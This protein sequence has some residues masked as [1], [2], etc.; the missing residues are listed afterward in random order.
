MLPGAAAEASWPVP[1]SPSLPALGRAAF[2]ASESPQ[3]GWGVLGTLPWA[4]DQYLTAPHTMLHGE[5][6]LWD[7]SGQGLS[8]RIFGWVVQ[9]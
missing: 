4:F 1:P 9:V 8:A 7:L 6:W 5:G 3:G 2:I